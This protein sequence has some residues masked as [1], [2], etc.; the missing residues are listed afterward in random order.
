MAPSTSHS[1]RIDVISRSL[2]SIMLVICVFQMISF[3]L[4][5]ERSIENYQQALRLQAL[6]R[7]NH[8]LFIASAELAREQNQYQ[9]L[10]SNRT[11]FSV[12]QRAQ[13]NALRAQVDQ[14]MNQALQLMARDPDLISA[15]VLTPL[16]ER[17]QHFRQLRPELD[18][19]LAQHKQAPSETLA[20][21]LSLATADLEGK[22]DLAVHEVTRKLDSAPDEAIGRLAESSYLLWRV[23]NQVAADGSAMIVRAQ[24][25]HTLNSSDEAALDTGRQFADIVMGQLQTEMR[26]LAQF[27]L[28]YRASDLKLEVDQFF[29]LSS[30]QLD[31]LGLSLP[32]PFP[33]EYYQHKA[34][35]AQ[36]HLLALFDK[37]SATS[38]AL[39]TANSQD[40]IE[41]LLR[42]VLL[43]VGAIALNLGL[44]VWLRR[45]VLQPLGLLSTIQDAAREAIVLVD[46]SGR[47]FM[48]NR[49][50]EQLFGFNT[51][52]L[53]AMRISELLS[54]LPLSSERM[55]TLAQSGEE[56][57]SP[58]RA[59]NGKP[60]QVSMI[61]SALPSS[62]GPHGVL[63]ILR[64]DQ[65][66]Y[67]AEQANQL[68][69][70][71]LSEVTRI[72]SLLFTQAS[73]N[74]VFNELLEILLN[75]THGDAACLLQIRDSAVG[76]LY[77]CRD[78][79]GLENV[80]FNREDSNDVKAL[81]QSLTSDPHW[82]LFPV[83][84]QNDLTGIMAVRQ[85]ELD[86][87][88]NVLEPLLG[89]YASI[90]SFVSEEEG[91]K[92]SAAQLNEVLRLQEALFSASP[93]GLIQIDAESQ[94]VRTNFHA[95]Q[96]FGIE[97]PDMPAMGLKEVLNT[98]QAWRT[99]EQRIARIRQGKQAAPCELECK[100]HAGTKLWVL[101]EIRPLYADHP[102]E[103]MILSC[104]D[105]TT[106][107]D[108]EAA[109]REARDNA[110]EAR[111]QLIAA[112]A[113]IPEAFAFYDED[114]HLV[115]CN[116]QYSDLFLS[117]IEPELMIGKTFEECARHSID[118]G[119]ET[120][121]EG[122]DLES[123]VQERI[124]RHHQE[125]GSFVLR[126]GEHWYIA[127]DHQIPGLGIVCLRSNISKLKIQEQELRQ[128]KVKADD[129]NQAKSAFLASISHE[130]RTPLNG[131][132]GLLELLRL[133]RLDVSQ[134]DTLASV[135]DSAQTLLRLIDDILDFSKIEAGKLELN[136]EP[137]A[138]RPLMEKVRDL[139][140]EIATGKSLGFTLESDPNLAA[141]HLADPLRL[142]QILQ[143]FVSNALKFTASGSV[144]LRVAVLASDSEQQT[145]RFTCSDSGIGI[146]SGS[147][148][149]LFQ[150]FSQAE[151][152]TTRRFGG[153]GLG[154]A[155][156][157]RLA[158]QMG[159][160]VA[161]AS[162]PGQGTTASL[163]VSLPLAQL[164]EPKETSSTESP[165]ENPAFSTDQAPI[166]F[167]EDNPTNRKLTMMQ[168]ERLGVT[169][170]VAEN[171]KEAFDLW[172]QQP[173]S[174]VLTDCHM[175]IMDGHQ[176]AQTIR[177]A[178]S[179]MEPGYQPVPIIACT[180][181]IGKDEAQRALDA[182]MNEVLTKP[183]GL[184][185]LSKM[186]NHWL[187]SARPSHGASPMVEAPATITKAPD[188]TAQP[189]HPAENH[190]IVDRTTL[191]VY[192]QGDLA[193]ELGILQDF[194]SSEI[195][196]MEALRAAVAQQNHK[197]A[198]WFTHRI[199][200]AGRMVGALPLA[201]AAEN[202]EVTAKQELPMEAEL[203][204]LEQA[205]SDLT[206]WVA[207]QQPTVGSG[208]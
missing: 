94:V 116:Q 13:L 189:E 6:D 77:Q 202:L 103:G 155:I 205:F 167:V 101:F 198:R 20:F 168:L 121:E 134:L 158:T 62:H 150:P 201:N 92:Q 175:P 48:A 162:Q 10:L 204:T 86:T 60:I 200:G 28:G 66:R 3:G 161:L 149:Q 67:Q 157:K 192:S 72:Q 187:G 179:M 169:F 102:C 9:T 55:M 14:D 145:L 165:Q 160:E 111:H 23:R 7:I 140:Q 71:L 36:D 206:A 93:A 123:W 85:P 46:A 33:P 25:A 146:D 99:L 106:L 108:S 174:L 29:A 24:M 164:A 115:V 54:E 75:Y 83:S 129:A 90:L 11:N 109:L 81:H 63:M 104:I 88:K 110:A 163:T 199:K 172:Q 138:L 173:F 4:V 80:E 153:T 19:Q 137:V 56:V 182:G 52:Q 22:T 31:Q 17:W 18:Q 194:L 180:A 191:E 78:F 125:Q 135:Q 5:I 30:G 26:F 118:N 16:I 141:A 32:S 181:N 188:M 154:L 61:A 1:T 91:R 143:N 2:L 34:D 107:K 82:T 185:A 68:N 39:I 37:L 59:A 98:S 12:E 51:Q 38:S 79:V 70:S 112:I 142:R 87:L 133:T 27:N 45:R 156:C 183:I 196:D 35:Q 65:E 113:A 139:Y 151:S 190:Q 152:S 207:G 41:R 117:A 21:E 128:A 177:A 43:L 120:M 114:D 122:F 42:F 64:N 105:I 127:S 195:E 130:I 73:R 171:G 159:G 124:R 197:D 49:G 126:I 184:E 178:E 8:T 119:H 58:A 53:H 193:I 203:A 50:A 148:T 57:R 76:P 170:R 144:Q 44:L 131:I 74:R 95:C 15:D 40:S 89:L 176:L 97:E 132:L 136:L 96:I 84:L 147:L 69:L 47:I 208:I 100:S 166:L 186:L